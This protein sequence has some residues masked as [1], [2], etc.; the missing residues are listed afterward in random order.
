MLP[1]KNEDYKSYVKKLTD[2]YYNKNIPSYLLV[3]QIN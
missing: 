2:F 3:D 1:N